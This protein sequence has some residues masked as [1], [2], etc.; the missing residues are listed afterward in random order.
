[1]NLNDLVSNDPEW[2]DV[3]KTLIDSVTYGDKVYGIPSAQ[4]Y[5]GFFANYDLINKYGIKK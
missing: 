1:M 3:D 5:L 4:N 2:A